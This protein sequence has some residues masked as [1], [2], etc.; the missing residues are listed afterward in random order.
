MSTTR[1]LTA[2]AAALTAVLLASGASASDPTL[3]LD[4]LV[5]NP[6]TPA[7]PPL[8][9]SV[10]VVLKLAGDP[11]AVVRSR[12]PGKQ[13]SDG[14]QRSIED[15][16]RG[17]QDALHGLI[18]ANGGTV[19]A[20]FQNA[21]NGI[22][23][24]VPAEKLIAVATLPG[25]VGVKPV[26]TYTLDN[27]R[28][29]PFIGAD[30]VWQGAAG[31]RGEHIKVAIIDTG[32]DYTH[33]NFG[34]PGTAAAF[35]AAAA[36]STEPADQDLFGPDAPKVKGGTDLVGDDYNASSS[37]PAKNTPKPDP[38]P[39]DCNGHGSHVA[40]TAAG[41]G[42]TST[43]ATYHGP[44]DATTYKTGA[45]SNGADLRDIRRIGP[46]VAPL[47]DLYAVRVFGCS[48]STNVVVEALEWAVAHH[49]QVVN[50]SLGA[51]FGTT[52][53]ADAE[54]SNNAVDA[55]IV[56]V[57]SAGNN[58][59]NPYITGSPASGEKAISVAAINSTRVFPGASLKLSTNTTV[60]A[61]NANGAPFSDGSSLSIVVLRT[62]TGAISLG[63]NPAE[64]T[65]AVS[66][67]L[68]VTARGTCARV[69]RAVFGQKAGAAAVLMVNNAAGF[70]PF[71]GPISGNPDTGEPFNV[72][73]PFLGVEQATGAALSAA[74]G[75]TATLTNTTIANPAF[76]QFAGFSSGGPR[77]GDGHLKPDISAPGVGTFST[78][79][80]SGNQGQFLSGTSM[81]APHVTGVAALAVQSHPGWETE[82]VRAA[83][84]NTADASQ[85]AG[86]SARGGGSGLVQ[87]FGATR[88]SVIATNKSGATNLSFGVEQFT[89]D[90]REDAE[91]QV[92][93]LGSSRATFAV[94]VIPGAGSP[95][96]LTAR[97]S[98]ISIRGGHREKIR[99]TL[100]IPA[101]TA[102]S[103]SAFR[104][105]SGQ[106]AL[107]P[108]TASGNGGVAL[109]VPYFV[110]PR[111]RSRIEA[112]LGSELSPAKPSATVLLSNE[113]RAV[114]GTAD[115]YA[116]GL[117]GK[118]AKLGSNG[119]RAVGVQ[120]R[121]NGTDRTLMF[122]VNTFAA[123][124]AASTKEFDILIDV[125]HDGIPD[126]AVLG[127]D[128]GAL[129]SGGFDGR[130]GAAVVDLTNNVIT[131]LR[132]AVAPTDGSTILLPVRASELTSPTDPTLKTHCSGGKACVVDAT[133]PTF[134]Y[135]AQLFD[136]LSDAADSIPARARFNAFTPAI[137]TGAFA[138]IGPAGTASV[139]LTLNPT[140][141][142]DSPAL[143]AM[144]VSLDNFSGRKQA[145][146]LRVGRGEDDDD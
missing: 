25:V 108:T 142:A 73:I 117:S 102:G 46:G 115:F 3:Q 138:T 8:A 100:Q 6:F 124:S 65:K 93:N 1:A 24:Q 88:T 26:A 53:T 2:A 106:I 33:A 41:F 15:Q 90:F 137:S 54:A 34:G 80:G 118:N 13:I 133:N 95:H 128:V 18:E 105:V 116:W 103:A 113:S 123:F 64:Y 16:L 27:I 79:V 77:N 55:G 72:T 63:C 135:T 68:V 5:S 71:E 122:A 86:F 99:V 38:N 49:M 81:A 17:D 47:A 50:M 28:S 30:A 129:L 111:A 131:V 130:P 7:V 74:A 89:R 70:P 62:S 87:P 60:S 121:A 104:Q 125:D 126:F 66:G 141:F 4:P 52:D 140:V 56:V 44:Y 48:G 107:S 23:V 9:G 75:G 39:L 35:N 96:T 59:P 69:A 139:T 83:I 78:L 145:N 85:V 143:G 101:A 136:V 119:L 92:R 19:L 76:R 94:T 98:T 21:I 114:G 10:T 82:D 20:K 57:A 58:G 32:I 144:I 40:G 31:F 91:L 120:S 22:K 51:P 132:L 12:A 37:D 127:F 42:V 146:L 67:K 14:E 112:E 134:S 61:I 43:G 110:V 109:T 29:V 45:F 97:P 11:V 36:H 84:V